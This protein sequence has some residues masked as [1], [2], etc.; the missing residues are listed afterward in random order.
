MAPKLGGR[1]GTKGSR[2]GK[3]ESSDIPGEGI[4]VEAVEK[5]GGLPKGK[6][7]ATRG[8]RG[9][10]GRSGKKE[11]R[12]LPD[13]L[14]RKFDVGRKFNEE[15]HHRFPHNEVHLSNGKWVDSY[16]PGREIVERKYTQLGEVKSGTARRYI[17]SLDNKYAPGT[18]ISNSAKNRA[19]GI[20]GQELQGRK[21]LEVPPQTSRISQ[22]VLDFAASRNV[23][24]R[25]VNGRVYR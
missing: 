2:R 15:N 25:D 21:I 4:I 17:A 23:L 5:A 12:P 9:G 16:R 20:A 22:E 10:K 18:L 1:K 19:E 24:I 3:K 7:K 11:K 6:G 14:R 13:W 8:G